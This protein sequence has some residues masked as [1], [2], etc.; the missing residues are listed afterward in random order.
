MKEITE[1]E[2]TI[3]VYLIG[4]LEEDGYLRREIDLI[5]DD[6][7][8]NYNLST[9]ITEVNKVLKLIQ[10]FDP[11]GVGAVTLQECLLLQL[12]RKPDKTKEVVFAMEI[13]KNHME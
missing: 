7:A 2:Y 12:E 1:R 5:V 9:D 10:S 11:A 6:L 4:C 8:F 3:G 13:I